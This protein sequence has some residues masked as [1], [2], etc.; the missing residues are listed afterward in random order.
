ML[1]YSNTKS[2]LHTLDVELY[3]H[4]SMLYSFL[5]PFVPPC[6]CFKPSLQPSSMYVLFVVTPIVE[7]IV[8][9]F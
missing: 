6:P 8:V 3:M 2:E 9:I 5:F 1:Y 4:N 7:N